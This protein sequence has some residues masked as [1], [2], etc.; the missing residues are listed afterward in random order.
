MQVRQEILDIYWH[1]ASQRQEIFFARLMGQ[2][3]PWT[4]DP[5]LHL[6]KFCNTYRASDRVS[7]YLLGKVIYA[8]PQSEEDHIFRIV[9]FKMFNQIRT[10]EYLESQVGHVTQSTFSP[11]R[12]DTLLTQANTQFPIYTNAYMS[13]ATKAFGYARKHQN[14]LALIYK[15]FVKDKLAKHILQ[16]KSFQSIFNLLRA[17]PLIGNFM[18]YQLT[19]DLNYSP[20]INFSETDFV[21]PGP[22][23]LRGMTKCFP[24]AR[25]KDAERII[26]SLQENQQEEFA[27]RGISF[28]SLFGRPLQLIDCQGLF[29]ETD[30]Y[31]R[32]SHPQL[33][34]ARK[35]IKQ[36]FIPSPQPFSLCYPPKWGLIYP[37]KTL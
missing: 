3:A 9:L 11:Q 18:A 30:K 5:I 20:V 19:T 1:F 17:Y 29:C 15:M 34:S 12:F 35:Q 8:Q 26:R 7:Q 28:K 13:C 4:K 25:A 27:K 21:S 6:H 10:W 14:H 2:S 37:K 32:V 31:T 36:K 24:N 22:G 33:K 23:A 16:A